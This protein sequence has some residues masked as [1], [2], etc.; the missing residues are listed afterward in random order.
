M[1]ALIALVGAGKAVFYDTLD[2][3]CFLHLL[4]A[5][6]MS[7]EGIGP[8]VDHHSFSSVRT[9]W[10]PYSWLAELGMKL[11]WDRGGYC[12]AVA[13]HALLA[14]GIVLLIAAA[15][16]ERAR[17]SGRPGAL[18]TVLSTAFAA[19]L[20][21]AYLS[22][23]PAT[24]ALGLLALCA[25]LLIRD[26]R[27][28]EKSRA[29]WLI[30]PITLLL[31]NVHLYAILVPAWLA[32]LLGGAIWERYFE[33]D[34]MQRKEMT[35]RAA[36][37]GL[38]TVGCGLA[39]LGTPMLGGSVR[40]ILFYQFSDPMVAG[41]VV[42]EYQ[43]FY[44]GAAGLISLALVGGLATC[45]FLRRRELRA[46][47]ILWLLLAFVLLLRM[48]RFAPIFAMVAAPILTV[49][50]PRLSDRVLARPALCAIV[51]AIV[52]LGGW[53]ICVS[54]PRTNQ[55]LDAFLNRNGPE[56]P[57]YPCAAAAFVDRAIKPS[58]GRI[59][60]E[61]SWGGYLA[62]RLRGRYQVFVDG[63]TAIFPAELWRV[64]YLGT[65]DERSRT[66]AQS[67][68]DAAILPV[69]RSQFREP[70]ERL[71]WTCRYRDE[72]AMVM[73]PPAVPIARTE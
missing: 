60:N 67:G 45:V 31:V 34:V 25:W 6:Q 73:V 26:R 12:A 62:W 2:P 29:V 61:Y 14:G 59:I 30:I 43:A 24:A 33:R 44:H 7:A 22:F 53:R 50:L 63:N 51:G 64:G 4:A 70:L 49:A 13:A 16:R 15:C 10:T 28:G 36:R 18:A 66:L 46:G 54:F 71:G 48:G 32:A 38:L 68:A 11:V 69:G 57:G 47:E 55:P 56:T 40:S 19:Y 23:R 52:A 41:P 58:S 35:R 39:C 37:Y 27:L 17:D 5:E 9:P 72:R 20:A 21:L 42:A 1:V 3:D 8:L 65:V